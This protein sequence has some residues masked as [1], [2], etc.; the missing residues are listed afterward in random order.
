MTDA[1][2]QLLVKMIENI[3]RKVDD[4]RE[5]NNRRF[6][7]IDK[8][9]EQM[10]KRFEQMDK[11]LDRIEDDVRADRDKLQEVYEARNR[12]AVKFGW[13]WSFASVFIAI[14]AVSVSKAFI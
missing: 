1:Q 6:E 2:F 9:F 13:Q 4:F 14:F 3:D 7:Q 11:R 5:E 8:R 12:V 10:D